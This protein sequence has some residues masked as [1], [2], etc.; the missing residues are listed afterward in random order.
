MPRLLCLPVLLFFLWLPSQL[1]AAEV[2][3]Q[4]D[5]VSIDFLYINANA[6]EAAGG[7]T[8]LRLGDAVFHYQFFPD[9]TFLLVREPWDSFRFLYNDLHNRSIAIAALPLDLSAAIQIRS[10][11][12]ELLA[13]QEQFFNALEQ[14]RQEKRFV[15]SLLAGKTDVA[16]DCLGFFTNTWRAVSPSDLPGYIEKT[17]GADFLEF[18]LKEVEGELY[19]AVAAMNQGRRP[20]NG[21]QEILALR[22]ALRVLLDNRA[23]TDD[24]LIPAMDKEVSLNVSEREILKAFGDHLAES[25]VELL[26]SRRP[27]RGTAILLQTAR[28]LAVQSSLE[29]GQMLTLDPFFADVR[30]VKL[31]DEDIEGGRL[32]ILQ[33]GL[34]EQSEKRRELFF[35][36][37]RH[38]EIAYTLM[39][40][41]RARAWELEQVN[42]GQRRVRL[43]TKV[44]LPTRS[45]NV[46]VDTLHPD[47]DGVKENIQILEEEI[48]E[49]QKKSEKLYG[50]NLFTRNCATE[51]IRS[52]NSTFTDSESGENVLGGWMEPD[53]GFAF[54]P[55]LFYEQSVKAFSLQ[56]EQFL[57]ARRLRN[58][59]TLYAE[60]NDFVVWLRESNTV[61]S[62][63]YQPRSKDTP[64]LFFT[65]DSL[66]LRPLLGL[67]NVAYG[68]AH[69][70]A[71]LA[72]LPLDGRE[73]LNQAL[74]GIFYS[75]PELTFGNIRKGS[76]SM[77]ESENRL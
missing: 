48:A 62:T 42:G 26:R 63:L 11:F 13:A 21:F 34:L 15:E 69:G 58:L 47:S 54:I 3:K 67:V 9:S 14:L 35:K 45:G 20:G 22:E 37:G 33:E 43:L 75:L 46:T 44:T 31:S 17:L 23:L 73:N 29:K 61:S 66:L 16:V 18:T 4:P 7:H 39:E 74:R 68:I 72:M 2:T 52:L 19:K 10:H 56:D 76:Y 64:F 32:R 59:E 71:G 6:G 50:Y 60:E 28:F 27:D 53:S 70:V 25:L 65:D 1:A 57:Q 77:G 49:K 24:A 5:K 51:L 12:A 55:F 38:L 30:E 36:E 41:G 40:T 8:A